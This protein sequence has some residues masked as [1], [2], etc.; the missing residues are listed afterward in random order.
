MVLD[1]ATTTVGMKYWLSKLLDEHDLF[2]GRLKPD[3][4]YRQNECTVQ[5]TENNSNSRIV[6]INR[7]DC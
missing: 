2:D 7:F 1:A 5:A 6:L 3:I 4:S